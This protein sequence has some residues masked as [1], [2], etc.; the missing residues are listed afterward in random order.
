MDIKVI[1]DDEGNPKIVFKEGTSSNNQNT[2]ATNTM[3][4]LLKTIES[5][6]NDVSPFFTLVRSS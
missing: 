4:Q 3:M 1:K 2:V 6:I 5:S